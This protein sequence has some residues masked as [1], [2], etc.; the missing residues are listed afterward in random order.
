MSFE[1]SEVEDWFK[2]E[3]EKHEF[4]SN[5]NNKV[6]RSSNVLNAPPPYGELS[7]AQEQL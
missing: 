2:K 4:P 7:H 3:K 6:R 5:G 1:N